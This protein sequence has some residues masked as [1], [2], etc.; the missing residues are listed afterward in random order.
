MRFHFVYIIFLSIFISCDDEVSSEI[1]LLDWVNDCDNGLLISKRVYG[2][3]MELKYLPPAYLAYKD[4]AVDK[5]DFDSLFNIYNNSY[6]FLMTI[7]PDEEKGADFDIMFA[8]VNN[9]EEYDERVQNLNFNIKEYVC[10]QTEK[11]KYLPVLSNLEN[12]YGLDKARTIYLVFTKDNENDDLFCSGK[13]D[14]VFNDE[15]FS[16]GIHHFVF[17]KNNIDNI[18]KLKL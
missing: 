2:L 9:Y 5:S 11:K 12:T 1:D 16:T 4:A 13:I 10:L 15:L 6:S 8:D 18:P 3:K 14:I 17:N 7:G